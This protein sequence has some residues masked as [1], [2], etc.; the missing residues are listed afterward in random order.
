MATSCATV[1]GAFADNEFEWL[2]RAMDELMQMADTFCGAG[3]AVFSS[4]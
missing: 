4:I 1:I 2:D 3:A